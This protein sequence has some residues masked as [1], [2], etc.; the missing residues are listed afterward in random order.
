MTMLALIAFHATCNARY[1]CQ[2]RLGMFAQVIQS[3]AK[4]EQIKL[5]H[6]LVLVGALKLCMILCEVCIMCSLN[7]HCSPLS[8][9]SNQSLEQE[10]QWKRSGAVCFCEYVCFWMNP[11]CYIFYTNIF[12]TTFIMVAPLLD[13][14][15]SC[16]LLCRG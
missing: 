16:M 4:T 2:Q 3:H 6:Q 10:L 8:T 7:L 15:L 13:L 5:S 1:L 12:C 9:S 14:N 11:S